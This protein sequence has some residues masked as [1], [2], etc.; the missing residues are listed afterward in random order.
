MPAG[1][2]PPAKRKGP[3]GAAAVPATSAFRDSLPCACA[4]PRRD[5]HRKWAAPRADNP[6]PRRQ[7]AAATLTA[8]TAPL[9]P[10]CLRRFAYKLLASRTQVTGAPLD[11]CHHVRNSQGAF[12]G[13]VDACRGASQGVLGMSARTRMCVHVTAEDRVTCMH[14]HTTPP[15]RYI[16]A[17]A[18]HAHT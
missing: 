16:H 2:R 10:V 4:M 12:E 3:S 11:S 13:G 9:H 8:R 14:M 17:T 15:Y 1:A 7:A 6:Q 5:S 18:S